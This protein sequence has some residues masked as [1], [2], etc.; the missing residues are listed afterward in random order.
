[1][2]KFGYMTID[3]KVV[4][5]I[6]FLAAEMI[7]KANSGHPGLPLGAAEMA[8]VLWHKFLR[9]DPSQPDWFGRDRFVLSAG[10]GS[11]LLYSLLHLYGFKLP[12][13]EL[14]R[15]RQLGSKT[16]GHPEHGL[17]PGVETTTGPLG[18]GLANA[19]GM[20]L[21]SKI[22][23]QRL[24]DQDG[25]SPADYRVFALV[26]D[27]CLME[28][29]SHEAMSLAGSL[30]LSNLVVLY[31]DNNITIDGPVDLTSAEDT[32]RRFEASD[33][34]V[35][36]DVSGNDINTLEQLFHYATNEGLAPVLVRAETTIGYGCSKAGSE[37]THGE[38]LGQDVIDKMK[39]S[40]DWP[41]AEPF[42]VPGEVR[43][44]CLERVTQLAIEHEKWNTR[45][46][47]WSMDNPEKAAL[48]RQLQSGDTPEDLL[49]TLIKA[50]GNDVRATRAHSGAVL[51]GAAKVFPGLIGGSADL[52]PSNKTWIQGS[53][54]INANDFNQ[55]NIHF[56]VRE[57]GMAG[58]MNGMALSG[59]IPYGGTFL[60][61]ADYMKPSIRMAAMMKL[62]VIYILTHDSIGVGED[63]PT[64]QPIE[65]LALLRTIPNLAVIRP[66]DGLEAAAAWTMAL[67]RARQNQGP[68]ALILS[69]QKVPNLERPTTFDDQLMMRGGYIIKYASVAAAP[70]IIATGSEVALAMVVAEELGARVVS[71]PSVELFLKQ[72]IK[73]QNQVIPANSKVVVIEA[74]LDPGWYRFTGRS[75]LI[76]GMDSFGASAPGKDLAKYF[77][78]ST[79][80]V[81]KKL[82]AWLKD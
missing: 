62:G 45:F 42:S 61:F 4:W 6:R 10:H 48:F 46:L 5:T 2:S 1:M 8:F 58:V 9:F 53:Q 76:I 7:Q 34:E 63:G 22:L 28:G 51:Q 79:Q 16:P 60:A 77:G 19:V 73:Y 21:A 43:Q 50:V 33:W 71:M 39:E 29:I 11:A 27:G 18:Q 14:Q 65:Q 70:V 37:K 35:Q 17:T 12:M 78:F 74:S 25:W 36:S 38:P 57:H 64:H 26:G 69:R 47:K 49:Q 72:P 54:A 20:A 44:H 81:L 40:V 67:Q 15:F 41:S 31:D 30:G 32:D 66:A 24:C 52:T 3:E 55:R 75:G 82:S 80:A 23:H 59:L 56:G 13:E 68:T